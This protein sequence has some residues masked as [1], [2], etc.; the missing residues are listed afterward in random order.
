MV[1]VIFSYLRADEPDLPD[2]YF[3]QGFKIERKLL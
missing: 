1:M 2:D 3:L